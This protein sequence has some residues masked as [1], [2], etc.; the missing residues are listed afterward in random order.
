MAVFEDDG[1]TGYFYAVDT[2]GAARHILD[3]LLV[4]NVAAVADRHMPSDLEVA[5]SSDACKAFLFI[6]R[7]PH[8]AFD[9]QARRGYCRSNF[10]PPDP[11]WTS[12]SHEWLDSVMVLL[13]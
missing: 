2:S 13:V 9:F 4:Y 8:A 10:P 5:W 1:D 11:H 6:N 3:A 7:Y 12:F